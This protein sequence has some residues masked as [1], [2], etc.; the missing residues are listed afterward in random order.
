VIES[1]WHSRA[2]RCPR[3]TATASFDRS[4]RESQW[5]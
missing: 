1:S 3:A 5:G 4:S 2:S